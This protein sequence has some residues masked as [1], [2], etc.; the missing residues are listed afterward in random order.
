MIE[1]DELER[2]AMFASLVEAGDRGLS[3]GEARK[4]V[5]DEFAATPRQVRG[6]ELEGERE[7]WPPL[8]D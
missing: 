2:R 4:L 7:R 6:V 1:L 5:G 8:G 3:E